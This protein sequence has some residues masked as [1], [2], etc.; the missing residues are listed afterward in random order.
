MIGGGVPQSPAVADIMPA[1]IVGGSVPETTYRPPVLQRIQPVRP[2]FG[3][4]APRVA[5]ATDAADAAPDGV[6]SGY[7]DLPM[8]AVI[9]GLIV[10]AYFTLRRL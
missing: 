3:R 4:I 2:D 9:G 8:P 1:G 6:P 10:V 5:V 7:I